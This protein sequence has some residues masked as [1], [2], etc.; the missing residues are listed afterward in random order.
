LHLQSVERWV[1]ETMRVVRARAAPAVSAAEELRGTEEAAKVDTKPVV[2]VDPE[3][4]RGFM[5]WINF[6]RAD[7]LRVDMFRE[8]WAHM[9][10]RK[11]SAL[12]WK[13]TARRVGVDT[14]GDSQ[15]EAV[16]KLMAAYEKAGKPAG[17]PLPQ[18][19]KCQAEHLIRKLAHSV[20]KVEQERPAFDGDPQSGA[21]PVGLRI[22]LAKTLKPLG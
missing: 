3:Y 14:S 17:P 6:L 9:V 12:N 16:L 22:P 21:M 10:G 19:E 18:P 5:H 1:E 4:H 2:E 13:Y 8:D 7:A 15:T 11:L 20:C